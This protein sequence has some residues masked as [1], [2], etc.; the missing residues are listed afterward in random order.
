MAR[1]QSPRPDCV[2][3]YLR[4]STTKQGIDGYGVDAQ[5]NAIGQFLATRPQLRLCAEYVEVES[6]RR[7]DRPQLAKAIAHAKRIKATLLIAKLDRLSRDLHMLTGLMRQGVHFTACDMPELDE[8]GV[9]LM[10]AFA[11]HEARLISQRTRAALAAA[12]ARGVQLGTPD[13][14]TDAGRVKGAQRNVEQAQKAYGAVAGYALSMRREG[15]T[16]QAIADRLNAEGLTTRDGAAFRAMTVHRIVARCQ[17]K[18][19]V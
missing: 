11:Q 12:K 10:G 7:D 16:F 1:P 13:N 14:F 8:F 19:G 9:T 6:G 3:A 4:V 17:A 5:R 2:I 18:K 15:L